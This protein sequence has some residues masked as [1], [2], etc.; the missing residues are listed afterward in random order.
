VGVHR[1]GDPGVD[2]GD[3]WIMTT[4]HESPEMETK[5]VSKKETTVY[6]TARHLLQALS[7]L[8]ESLLDLPLPI[9]R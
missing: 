5:D 7:N 6:Y 3:E 9:G 1:H 2:H 8:D 4:S